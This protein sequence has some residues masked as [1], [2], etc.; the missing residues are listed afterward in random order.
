MDPKA[1]EAS[2]P[3]NPGRYMSD[4]GSFHIHSRRFLQSRGLSALTEDLASIPCLDDKGVTELRELSP[5]GEE[6][7]FM[8]S[9][10]S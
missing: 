4:L 2:P 7:R 8:L 9:H 6:Q 10:H 5:P 1:P 3:R